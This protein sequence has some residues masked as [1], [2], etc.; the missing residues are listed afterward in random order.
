MVLLPGCECIAGDGF[1]E[2]KPGSSYDYFGSTSGL[3]VE[4]EIFKRFK[5]KLMCWHTGIFGMVR[6]RR[7]GGRNC[8]TARA[9]IHSFSFFPASF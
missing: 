8:G 3:A 5:N 2:A 4:R 7:P 9:L 1:I 6:R